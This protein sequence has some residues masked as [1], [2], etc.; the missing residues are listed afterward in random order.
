TLILSLQ[1]DSMG[2]MR[3]LA[4]VMPLVYCVFI[5]LSTLRLDFRLSAFTGF[6]AA[7]EL[8][9]LVMYYKP[10]TDRNIEPEL[11]YHLTRSFV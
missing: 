2:Q 1:I 5:I 4:F 11:Y 9:A 8:F 6:I 10:A 7:A 3:A